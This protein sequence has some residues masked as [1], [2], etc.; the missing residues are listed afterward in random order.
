MAVHLRNDA[1]ELALSLSGVVDVTEA[2]VVHAAAREV[3]AAAPRAVV[4][5]LQGLDTLDTSITQLLLALRQSLAANG[6]G[7]RIEGTPPAVAELWRR[8][9]LLDRLG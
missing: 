2:G 3:V 5:R 8:A 6:I 4:V 9:G 1:G 7:L